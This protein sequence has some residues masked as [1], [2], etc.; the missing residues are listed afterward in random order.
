MNPLLLD[1]TVWL[2]FFLEEKYL[3]KCICFPYEMVE[4]KSVAVG[5]KFIE[6]DNLLTDMT[7]TCWYSTISTY[8]LIQDTLNEVNDD[9]LEPQLNM[10]NNQDLL[11]QITKIIKVVQIKIYNFIQK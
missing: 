11:Y 1:L 9:L 10:L 7:E 5:S 3:M 8:E 2:N 4:N 6:T